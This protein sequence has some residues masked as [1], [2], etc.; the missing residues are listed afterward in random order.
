[1]YEIIEKQVVRN[2]YSTIPYT[3]I[4]SKSPKKRICIMLPGLGY[5]TQRPLFHYA[6]SMCIQENIDVFHINYHFNKNE[7]FIALS[8]VEQD[9]WMY[10]D[11]KAVV[12]EVLQESEYEQQ[13]WLC[14]SIGTIP[15]A[16]EWTQKN[17]IHHSVGVWLTPLLKDDNVYNAI[18]NTELPSLCVIGDQDPHYIKERLSSLE[19]NE[20]VRVVVIPDADHSLEIQEDVSATI[21]SMKEIINN[22]QDFI[23]DIGS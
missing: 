23:V 10:E 5:S 11:V 2:E 18:L 14:K 12:D 7:H 4:R 15:M 3:W 20:L 13:I 6:T 17:F 1:M 8:R 19:K 16:L 22:I 21:D 9:A